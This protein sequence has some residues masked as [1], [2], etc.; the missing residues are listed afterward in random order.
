MTVIY[1]LLCRSDEI[2]KNLKLDFIVMVSD[3]AIYCKTVDVLIKEKKLSNVILLMGGF[4]I[5]MNFASVIGTRSGIAG[6]RGVMIKSG[7][8]AAGSVDACP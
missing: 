6:L 2:R 7:I 8:V 5:I 4:H 1:S 3:H